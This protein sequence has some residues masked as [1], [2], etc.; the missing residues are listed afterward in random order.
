MSNRLTKQSVSLYIPA[1]RA[2]IG[3]PAYCTTQKVEE[4]VWVDNTTAYTFAHTINA[5]DTINLGSGYTAGDI[6]K[7]VYETIRVGQMYTTTKM[8]DK[9]VCYPAVASVAGRDASV[10]VDNQLGWNAGA[11]SI[12]AVSN[13]FK[14]S[15]NVA[16]VPVGV[17]CGVGSELATIGSFNE[18][19]HAFYA[20]EGRIRIYE[21]G[22]PVYSTGISPASLPDLSITRTGETIRYQ[23]NGETVY[24]SGKA[25][26]GNKV[27][28]A[29]LYC[30]GDLVDNPMLSKLYGLSSSENFDMG[31]QAGISSASVVQL[32]AAIDTRMSGTAYLSNQAAPSEPPVIDV[33]ALSVLIPFV[34]RAA[35][36]DVIV[37][38]MA[39]SLPLNMIAAEDEYSSGRATITLEASG[40]E[41]GGNELEDTIYDG[42]GLYQR[43][44]APALAFSLIR[45]QLTIGST[46]DVM[47]MIEGGSIFEGLIMREDFT[48]SLLLSQML[49]E[50]LT[51]TDDAR[52]TR[53]LALQYATNLATGAVTRYSG[54]DFKGFLQVDLDSYAYRP[55]GVYR[56]GG[57]TDN[58][59]ALQALIDFAADDFG[60]GATKRGESIYFGLTTDGQ[61]VAK[62]TEDN[63]QQ[64]VYRIEGQSPTMRARLGRG[65]D[66]KLWRL[67]LEVSD[68]TDL[69]LDSIE[70]LIAASSRRLTR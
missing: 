68:A 58:G 35:D 57:Q 21:S 12:N 38:E 4:L 61:A 1:V 39:A 50:G 17:L 65:L 52:H 48:V 43:Y 56:L 15:F 28:L 30:A 24:T 40:F 60:S 70:W 66:S 63:G 18:I 54:Y 14:A 34:M 62:V 45:E 27:L 46:F 2:I 44:T 32:S 9:T 20:D 6:G 3:H 31:G 33:T 64:Y 25:S 41:L 26:R 37:Y 22:K 19:E 42:L 23:V 7:T 5:S 36:T 11:R 55:D 16:A 69:Q 49:R 59:E 10:S 51:I 47:L 67:R 53:Q 13:D 29:S 8:V